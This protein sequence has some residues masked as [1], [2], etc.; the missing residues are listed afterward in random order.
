MID[1]ELEIKAIR[2]RYLGI[3]EKKRKIRR[4]NEKKFVFDWDRDE[5]TSKDYNPI[6]ANRHEVCERL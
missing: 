4:M 2:M 1:P 3:K 5:D 6:Y